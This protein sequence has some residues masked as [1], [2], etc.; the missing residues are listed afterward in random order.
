MT[1]SALISP[2]TSIDQLASELTIFYNIAGQ[3]QVRL[4]TICKPKV[5]TAFLELFLATARTK[6]ITADL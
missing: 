5:E 2:T 4:R 3:V 1:T 6:V